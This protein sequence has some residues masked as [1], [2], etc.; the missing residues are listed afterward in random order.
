MPAREFRPGFRFSLWDGV[1][2]VL[3]ALGA[4]N[5]ARVQFWWLTIIIGWVVGHF[6]LFCNVF[7]LSRGPELIW[8][9]GFI[10]VAGDSY[11]AYDYSRVVLD[12]GISLLL[13]VILLV[14]EMRKPYYH[15]VGWSKINPNLRG[16]WELNEEDE[17]S[18]WVGP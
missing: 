18:K 3:G 12:G 11:G 2:L 6:F 7:R 1:V 8:A 9:A 5:C 15:G 10:F 17:G 16:W 13:T 4:F 14:L